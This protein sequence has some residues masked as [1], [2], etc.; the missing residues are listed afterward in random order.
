MRQ[1][2]TLSLGKLMPALSRNITQAQTI[3]YFRGDSWRPG[4]RIWNKKINNDTLGRLGENEWNCIFYS[5][6]LSLCIH[7]TSMRL[8]PFDH[9][10]GCACKPN[11]ITTKQR[12][13]GRLAAFDEL[14]S[15]RC[16]RLCR[17]SPTTGRELRAL[18]T[19]LHPI[20]RWILMV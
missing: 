14:E 20:S 1:L 7:A 19:P 17:G 13:Q 2:N 6:L 15:S 5:N 12:G 16:C 9:C 8:P 10:I 11:P 18:R 4:L 3:E